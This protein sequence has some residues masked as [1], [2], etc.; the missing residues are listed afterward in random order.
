[1]EREVT[2]NA[3]TQRVIALDNIEA[4][5]VDALGVTPLAVTTHAS[6]PQRLAEKWKALP[7]LSAQP[8]PAEIA[9]LSP[10]IVVGPAAHV[11]P[12]WIASLTEDNVPVLFWKTESLADIENRIYFWGAVLGR[13]PAAEKIVH[14]METSI[15]KTR[16]AFASVPPKHVLIID[17]NDNG[18]GACDSHTLIGN[19]AQLIPMVNLADEL[20]DVPRDR[21]GL[22]PIENVIKANLQPQAVIVLREQDAASPGVAAWEELESSAYWQTL[23]A[24][25]SGNVTMFTDDEISATVSVRAADAVAL[26]AK[27]LYGP[28]DS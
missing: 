22:I 1:M 28:R 14:N 12:E 23:P 26:L 11:S 20:A 21:E 9:A 27:T 5:I 15:E 3:P 10:D 8:N 2:F 24:L 25:A 16:N 17:V 7:Q 6:L 4:K 13:E 18:V 19:L